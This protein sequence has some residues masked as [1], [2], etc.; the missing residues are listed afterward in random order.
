MLSFVS[1]GLAFSW[2]VGQSTAACNGLYRDGTPIYPA[3]PCTASRSGG[4]DISERYYCEDGVLGYAQYLGTSCSGDP[5]LDYTDYMALAPDE[6]YTSVC[7]GTSCAYTIYKI[8]QSEVWCSFP[9]TLY[10][11]SRNNEHNTVH[12]RRR[13]Q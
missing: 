12:I 13:L 10:A 11:N 1:V 4:L 7:D 9:L 6:T 2:F 5:A 3:G 8:S